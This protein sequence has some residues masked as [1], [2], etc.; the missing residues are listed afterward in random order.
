[1]S[2]E[3]GERRGD[4]E[5]ERE[6]ATEREREREREREEE[7]ETPGLRAPRMGRTRG[8]NGGEGKREYVGGRV[9]GSDTE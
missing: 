3:G 9:V 1:M 5:R 4:R 7:G 6:R 2:E 8:G